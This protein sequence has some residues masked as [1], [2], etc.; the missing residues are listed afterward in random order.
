MS[1]RYY[2]LKLK[3]DFFQTE[4]IEWLEEQNNGKEYVL[5]YLK[6]CLKSLK[7][8]GALIRQVGDVL[9][10][11]DLA[12]IAEIT[13]TNIDT[14]KVA[15]DALS[16][17]GLIEMQENGQLFM[18]CLDELV[19]SESATKEAVKKRKYRAKLDKNNQVDIL[20]LGMSPECPLNCPTE[21][22]DKSLEIR[23]EKKENKKEKPP[24]HKY[25]E[26]SNVLL[27]D[28]EMEKLKT[29]FSDDWHERI[30]KL[31]EYM[32]STGKSY[33]DHLATIRSWARRE[34][35]QTQTS[36]S[37]P[38]NDFADMKLGTYL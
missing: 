9:I 7:R 1:E 35:K 6:L 5:F 3:E 22:R 23:D 12:K 20:S 13:R 11:Y 16:R 28:G 30:D 36:S 21:Y 8:N 26:Y 34:N 14:A 18:C 27:S 15:L 25:G 24:R 2:W 4:T 10:P 31:S 29:E 17:I 32:R 19:G 33:K 37:K 38:K